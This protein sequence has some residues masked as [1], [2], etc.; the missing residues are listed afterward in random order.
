MQLLNCHSA[1]PP[2][3]PPTAPTPCHHVQVHDATSHQNIN[4]YI[5]A[6]DISVR[7]RTRDLSLARCRAS[8]SVTVCVT[9]ALLV[10]G[11]QP[12]K[13][14][15]KHAHPV[16]AHSL[17]VTRGQPRSYRGG[18]AVGDGADVSGTQQVDRREGCALDVVGRVGLRRRA[19]RWAVDS[20][21][22]AMALH[23]GHARA[24]SPVPTRRR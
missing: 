3:T 6:H 21:H 5:Y 18:G 2:A 12:R 11:A 9:A 13:F 23:M 4:R 20:G 7:L 17:R 19:L 14:G 10:A 15:L 8:Y 1:Q 16:L 22:W 24:A